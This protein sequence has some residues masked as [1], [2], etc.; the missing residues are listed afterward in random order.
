[1]KFQP[2]NSSFFS[3]IAYDPKGQILYVKVNNLPGVPLS[4]VDVVIS[5]YVLYRDVSI[6]P[7]FLIFLIWNTCQ[8][9]N[10]NQCYCKTYVP[11]NIFFKRGGDSIATYGTRG[12]GFA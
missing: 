4:M 3:S 9:M 12:T 7:K 6:F 5:P 1:M 8:Q 10:N 11:L 2:V